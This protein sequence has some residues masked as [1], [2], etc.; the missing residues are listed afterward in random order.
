MGRAR[1]AAFIL[2]SVALPLVALVTALLIV[3]LRLHARADRSGGGNGFINRAG[4]RGTVL[5][6]KA[7]GEYR[8]AVVGGSTAYGF[9]VN[10]DEAFPS[11]LERILGPQ[12]RLINLGYMG[13]GAYGDGITLRDYAYLKYDLVVLYEGY[14]D[15]G[16]ER[17]HNTQSFRHQSRVFAW[18]GYYP[19]FPV[20]AREKALLMLYGSIDAGYQ[21]DRP[22]ISA[23]ALRTG[24]ASAIRILA[25]MDRYATDTDVVRRAMPTNKSDP[26]AF[27]IFYRQQVMK[28]IRDTLARGIPVLLVG[29]P[30]LR[31]V[32]PGRAVSAQAVLHREAQACL[33][34]D[35]KQLD[36]VPGFHY[37]NIGDRVRLDDPTMTLADRL[38]LSPQGNRRV[39]EALAPTV[40]MIDRKSVV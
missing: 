12:A 31:D 36:Q 28:N 4:Y 29:Q 8:I 17:E 3:D 22:V 35:L 27:W 25:D 10:T 15:L 23:S 6:R 19:L 20:V 30:W 2:L 24:A 5:G 13:E 16:G 39:A 21:R 1:R 38:H 7:A 37:A 34:G 14:N 26:C 33:E 9:G 40:R 11:Q 32:G 18:T